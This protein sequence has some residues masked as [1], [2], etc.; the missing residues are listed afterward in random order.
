MAIDIPLGL[1][2]RP[3]RP[4]DLEAKAVVGALW[5]SVFMTPARAVVEARPESF[6]EACAL[7]RELT[8][9]GI[10][11]LVYGL[12]PKILDVNDWVST[13]PYPV[14]EVHPEV[15]FATMAGQALGTRKKTWGGFE[16][17]RRL[18]EEGGIAID[19]DL[20]DAGTKAGVDDVL[21]AAAA[22]WTALRITVGDARSF[23]S[24][25]VR[26]AS[27]RPTGTIWA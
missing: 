20:G 3:P 16:E 22:A 8:G 7:S 17:R 2:E 23:L 25:P 4:A 9:G 18:L 24:P 14:Y 11:Q 5:P 6:E 19:G 10:S 13:A 26:D 27:G 15:S 12:F 1:P 21:D